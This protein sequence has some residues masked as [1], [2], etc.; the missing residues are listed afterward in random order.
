M[1]RFL[2]TARKQLEAAV[3]AGLILLIA[4]QI[5][6]VPASGFNGQGSC[7]VQILGPTCLSDLIVCV[8]K[9]VLFSLCS[10]VCKIILWFVSLTNIHI[11][12]T[13]M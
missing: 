11:N 6:A 8:Y 5:I 10:N 13:V 7:G 4:Q 1:A 2:L 3:R 12:W 9:C